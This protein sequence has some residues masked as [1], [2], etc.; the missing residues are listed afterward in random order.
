MTQ[1]DKTT[2]DA[3][4]ILRG[5]KHGELVLS[6]G[7]KLHGKADGFGFDVVATFPNALNS[8]RTEERAK[9]IEELRQKSLDVLEE[10]FPKLNQDN[11]NESSGNGRGEAMAYR[12]LLLTT[13]IT[14]SSNTEV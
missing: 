5:K 7:G 10:H 8:T 9:T 14:H 4:E 13:I 3:I 2:E 11:P 12:A 6:I 1:A